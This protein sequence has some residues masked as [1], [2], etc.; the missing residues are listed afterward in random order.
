LIDFVVDASPQKQNMFLPA[1]HIPIVDESYIKR[2]KPDLI[3]VLPWNI[4]EEIFAQLDYIRDW[5]AKFVVAIP[6]LE[7]S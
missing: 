3:L 4:K 1:S 7:I 5:N 2:E 6:K